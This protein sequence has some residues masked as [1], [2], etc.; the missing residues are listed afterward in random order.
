MREYDLYPRHTDLH[1]LAMNGY[2]FPTPGTE[3]HF[4]QCGSY[5]PAVELNGS[6]T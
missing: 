5:L 3:V 2:P 1:N 4:I 6:S